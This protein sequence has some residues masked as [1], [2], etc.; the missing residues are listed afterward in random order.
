MAEI[1]SVFFFLLF[2]NPLIIFYLCSAPPPLSPP[3]V[4]P[5]PLPI[6]RRS[7]SRTT[8]FTALESR[9]AGEQEREPPGNYPAR[10]ESSNAPPSPP[11]QYLPSLSFLPLIYNFS[12][13]LLFSPVCVALF[14]SPIVS[15]LSESPPASVLQE[16]KLINLPLYLPFLR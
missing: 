3:S 16:S 8:H 2:L 12:I 9:E 4:P 5:S 13:F 7:T 1:G 15:L 10:D 14:F 11:P 6:T